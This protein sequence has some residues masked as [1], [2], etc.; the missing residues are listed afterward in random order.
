MH[1]QGSSR[2]IGDLK[3]GGKVICTWNMQMTFC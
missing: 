1:N 3:M 2:M